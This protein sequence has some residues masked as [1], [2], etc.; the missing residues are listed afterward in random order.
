[1]GAGVGVE[2]AVGRG[3]FVG[4]GVLVGFGVF[5]GAGVFVGRG[6]LVGAAVLVRAAVGIAVGVAAGLQAVSTIT[7]KIADAFTILESA[8]KWRIVR[9]PSV[10]GY[11]GHCSTK[12]P[13]GP[14]LT[15]ARLRRVT[16]PQH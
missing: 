2:V 3:V 6:V 5:V 8:N 9:L 16:I 1:M 12:P 11:G 4:F 10:F 14:E 13:N 7:S 15:C